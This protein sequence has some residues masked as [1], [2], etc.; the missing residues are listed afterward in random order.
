MQGPGF[1]L[2]QQQRKKNTY[3]HL[4]FY[5][6]SQSLN[7]NQIIRLLYR[8]KKPQDKTNMKPIN[9]TDLSTKKHHHKQL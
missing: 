1:N 7:H 2:Q 8:P 3:S 5:N 9:V 6:P 4:I